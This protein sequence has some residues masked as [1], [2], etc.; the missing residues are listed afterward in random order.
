M[1]GI[2]HENQYIYIY[3]YLFIYLFIYGH[4]LLTSSWNEKC[5]RQK[6]YRKSK[7]TFYINP[8][9]TKLNP[10]AQ[11]YLPRFFTGDFNF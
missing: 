9:T 6:L 3:L 1:M 5:F 2:L 4:I 10:F 7:H 11:G 8:L